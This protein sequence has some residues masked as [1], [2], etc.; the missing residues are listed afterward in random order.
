MA[1]AKLCEKAGTLH[2]TI[3]QGATF[4]PVLTWKD[5][6]GALIN[7]TGYSA[8]MQ[9]RPTVDDAGIPFVDATDL[10]GKLVL[11]GVAGTIT[12]NIPATD[13]AAL[14]FSEAVY[15]LEVE[16]AS[17]V[18]TRLLKGDVYLSPEVTK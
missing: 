9:I 10:N 2:I 8:R 6:A 1:A 13:T 4:N 17:G 11:G 3:E 5:Q 16:D 7:L 18:V 12:L 15:D 14:V